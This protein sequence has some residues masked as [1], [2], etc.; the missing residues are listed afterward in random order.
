MVPG[1]VSSLA[2][3]TQELL[4]GG[5]VRTPDAAVALP[6]TILKAEL[7]YPSTTAEAGV[8]QPNP[9]V[10]VGASGDVMLFLK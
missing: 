5:K 2:V 7:V 3:Q 6:T 10:S 9:E 1:R 4:V 8:V